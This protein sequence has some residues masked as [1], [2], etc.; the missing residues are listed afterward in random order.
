MA[1]DSPSRQWAMWWPVV[2]GV[3]LDLLALLWPT[4]CV[5]CGAADRDCCDECLAGLH[6][7]RENVIRRQLPSDG[8]GLPP[9]LF[10]SGLYAGPVRA[11][12]LACKHEGRTG[13]ARELGAQLRAPLAAA[14]GCARDGRPPIVVAAP[15]RSATV[16]E[17]GY[18]HLE[19]ILRNA[20]GQGL[21]LGGAGASVGDAGAR[22][23]W[24]VLRPARG[25]TG[26][27]GLSA[28]ERR[29]NAE[30]LYVRPGA[31]WLL[32]GREV[33]LV[34][35]I[36]TTGATAAAACRVLNEAGARV[37]AVAALCLVDRNDGWNV[38]ADKDA[39]AVQRP[40]FEEHDIPDDVS[41]GLLKG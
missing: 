15:S 20:V 39:V 41:T 8:A 35:D 18:R 36:V 14:M 19:L 21:L 32:H 5:S 16:R 37:V 1:V 25:R 10:A 13:F 17:R 11:L 12:L 33:V 29:R 26:Q 23:A 9:P 4:V 24:R 7:C 3:L 22:R 38:E 40:C 34:D 27:V 30:R 31:R 2:R 28:V 6:A